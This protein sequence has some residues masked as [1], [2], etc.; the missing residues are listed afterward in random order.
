M[1]TRGARVGTYEVLERV[2]AGGMGEVFR[3]RDSRLGRD[4]ALKVLSE[5]FRLDTRRR[6]RFER[7]ARVLASLNHPNIATLHGLE[8]V[9]DTQALVLEMVEGQTLRER[10]SGVAIP[11][12]EALDIAQQIAAAL[13]AAHEHGVMHRDL[14]PDNIKLRPDG[15]VKLLDFGLATVFSR[16]SERGG[17]Q[18]PT[19]TALGID[20]RPA[21]MGTP[22]YMSPEQARG[23]A[24]DKRTDIWAFGC[25]LYEMLTGQ[26]LFASDRTSDVV[27]QIIEREADFSALPADTPAAIR[28]LLRRCL[29]KDPRQRLRDVGDARVEIAEVLAATGTDAAERSPQS[30]RL[31]KTRVL[32]GVIGLAAAL[33]LGMLISN[34]LRD[35]NTRPVTRFTMILPRTQ[36][37]EGGAYPFLAISPQGSHLAYIAN[38][39]IFL[40]AMND[41]DARP[42]GGTENQGPL[43]GV[44]FSP[45]GQWIGYQSLRYR[46][47]RKVA[48]AGGTPVRLASAT[49]W[50]GGSWAEDDEILFAQTDGI[51]T[52]PGAGGTARRVIGVNR[53][54]GEL[55]MNPVRLPGDRG[56]LFTLE[57]S[58]AG[59]DRAATKSIV[60]QRPGA[61]GRRVLIEGGA[62]AR[63]LKSGHLL[64]ADQ[65]TLLAVRFDLDSLAAVGAPTP[66][67]RQITTMAITGGSAFAVSPDGSLIY[68][69]PPSDGSAY[70]PTRPLAWVDRQGR[71]HPVNA[72]PRAYNYFRVSPDGT[73]IATS[74]RDEGEEI[75]V[76]DV[77]SRTFTR[78]TFSPDIDQ[79]PLWTPDSARI[80]FMSRSGGK[81]TISRNAVDGTGS[82]EPLF[83]GA[84][85]LQPSSFTPD[86]AYLLY[87]QITPARESNLR[88]LSLDGARTSRA[89]LE[90]SNDELNGEISPDGRWLAYQS[91]ETGS[92]EI[93]IRPFP[94]VDAGKW[95]VTSGGGIQPAWG[96]K[97]RE[98]FYLA[99]RRLMNV[100]IRFSS[101]PAIGVPQVIVNDLSYTPYDRS[102]RT[103][104][105]SADGERLL[106]SDAPVSVSEEPF[107]G[108]GRIEIVLNWSEE[109][110]HAAR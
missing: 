56:V 30:T 9:G 75:Y 102:G 20:A 12:A 19:V 109:L 54:Q 25:V 93:F 4:V 61:T 35:P 71:R 103:Y 97:G 70:A 10:I 94:N 90:T 22:A 110:K 24:V 66:V 41:V 100:P 84:D 39:R 104:D 77:K 83:S 17:P 79:L 64:Y 29:V 80:V 69:A 107:A 108:L 105:V 36:V 8:E 59:S 5:S 37:P 81:T 101:T 88:L 63:Y 92:F 72:P 55:A 14:K 73:R 31:R 60:L 50:F 89:L 21:V 82:T 13:D 32:L 99:S 27:A 46:E 67:A 23:V 15:T 3:A 49:D 6:A 57:T 78:I 86:G 7:E 18:E 62:D 45:D 26:R 52:V 91:N 106:I 95:Q 53:E 38:N 44:L 76:W 96:R 58:V 1:L 68:H 28:R 65:R 16:E 33:G 85:T 48:L 42:V 74:V 11:C 47:L 40:R 98:L 34:S 2:G 87:R 51:F 43:V